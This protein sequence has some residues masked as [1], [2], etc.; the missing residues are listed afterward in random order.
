MKPLK[1]CVPALIG[2]C[3]SSLFL[4]FPFLSSL[5]NAREVIRRAR[6]RAHARRHS[7]NAKGN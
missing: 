7:P 2:L 5:A 4:S 3:E 6:N 1:Q